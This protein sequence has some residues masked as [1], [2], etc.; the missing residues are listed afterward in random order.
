MS[1]LRGAFALTAFL[2]C[3][4]LLSA[5]TL[6]PIVAQQTPNPA[7]QATPQER[8]SYDSMVLT[9]IVIDKKGNYVGGLDKSAFTIYDNK[10]PQEINFFSAQD[11]PLSVGVI[12][13]LS[14]SVKNTNRE[15]LATA[16]EAF[17]RFVKSGQSANEYFVITFAN[18]PQ[19]LIDWT[20][21]DKILEAASDLK[22]ANREG[23]ATA[24]YDACYLGIEKMRTSSYP[25][26]ALLLI[27]DGVDSLSDYTFKD[28]RERLREMGVPLYSIGISGIAE[29]G[30][31]LGMEGAAVMQELSSAS[32]GVAVFPDDKKKIN[33][34]FDLLARR[35]RHQYLLGFKPP[36]DKSDDKWHQLKIEVT[37]P[38][39]AAS[40]MSKL[41]ART[42]AGYYPAL[43]L[44]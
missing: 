4:I 35:L 39:N 8:P 19:L 22:R 13:D 30:S 18:R 28:V 5:V 23:G 16:A 38:S 42:R 29:P 33:D 17:S 1:Y 26:Q 44:R 27:S 2:L 32:G 21:G 10:L 31:T 6:P 7:G 36:T 3:L 9:V 15:L 14:S 25:K 11:E 24:L 20:R 43:S 40:S 37:P 41:V 12:F 34:A